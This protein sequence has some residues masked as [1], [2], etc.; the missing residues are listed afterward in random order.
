MMIHSHLYPNYFSEI[1][2]FFLIFTSFLVLLNFFFVS[3][4]CSLICLVHYGRINETTL[5]RYSP[6]KYDRFILSAGSDTRFYEV[7][8]RRQPMVLRA[9]MGLTTDRKTATKIL[10]VGRKKN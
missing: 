5:I 9:L 7:Y 2:C 10:P 1:L 6:M 8:L 3:F 4:C